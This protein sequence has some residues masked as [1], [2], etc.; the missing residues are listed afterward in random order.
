LDSGER[1][2]PRYASIVAVSVASWRG[3]DQPTRAALPEK[4]PPAH[5]LYLKFCAK[6]HGDDGTGTKSHSD[7]P[8]FTSA[9][10]HRDR[11]PVQLLV[12]VRDGKGRCM[13]GFADRL[14]DNELIELVTRVRGFAPPD[15]HAAPHT[16]DPDFDKQFQKLE[17][18][19][20][21]MRR[22]FWRL[23]GASK[24]DPQPAPSRKPPNR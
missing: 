9:A 18:E 12:S 7:V 11:S 15:R 22:E 6:C 19:L 23:N 2:Q 21:Q 14:K 1:P 4:P 5:R 20:E 17:L 10:W 3:L 13:P 24:P 8:D 16:A